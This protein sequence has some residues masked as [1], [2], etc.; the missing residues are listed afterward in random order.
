MMDEA[1]VR[2]LA[3]RSL[4]SMRA[5]FCSEDMT[6]A[7]EQFCMARAFAMTTGR[8]LSGPTYTWAAN[9]LYNGLYNGGIR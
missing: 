3:A 6:A 8:I 7:I 4:R 2:N 5:Y 1:F 9:R